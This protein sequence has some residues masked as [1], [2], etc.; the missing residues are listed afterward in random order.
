MQ[1]P[2]DGITKK[3]LMTILSQ[4]VRRADAPALL[5]RRTVEE[6]HYAQRRQADFVRLFLLGGPARR[7]RARPR[8]RP[9]CGKPDCPILKPER[10][11]LGLQFEEPRFTC[12]VFS[13]PM[14]WGDCPF[15][16]TSICA[17]VVPW[18]TARACPP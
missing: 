16:Q 15:H 6:R 11:Y 13:L 18:G 7:L 9:A 14:K 2:T 10:E 3:R 8:Q 17:L 4:T 12:S 1:D 5:W